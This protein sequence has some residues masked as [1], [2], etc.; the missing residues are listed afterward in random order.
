MNRRVTSIRNFHTRIPWL[1]LLGWA[2]LGFQ[3]LQAEVLYNRDVRP[4]LSAHCFK[5]HGPDED[6]RK[7]DL[8]LDI[9]G[10]IDFEE[11][12]RRISSE[13]PAERMPPPKS[14]QHQRPLLPQQIQTLQQWIASG[15]V[16][17]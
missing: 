7:V 2:T 5:C 13:D 11:V 15:S 10:E 14:N 6:Q 16:Y 8:R 1:F 12:L 3:Q 9:P 17:Q 4:L